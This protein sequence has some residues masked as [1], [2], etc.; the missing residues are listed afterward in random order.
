[1]LPY[2]I[3]PK[4]KTQLIPPPVTRT[5]VS[6]GSQEQL[7]G[8]VQGKKASDLEERAANSHYELGIP[9][10]FR[11]RISVFPV[12]KETL[13]PLRSD[14]KEIPYYYHLWQIEK[15]YTEVRPLIPYEM[16]MNLAGELE[17]DILADR[18]GILWPI[19]IDGEIGHHMTTAQRD[20]DTLKTD[21]INIALL[22]Y[23][24][25]GVV[26]VP[27]WLLKTQDQ[28]DEFFENLYQEI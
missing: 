6:L 11:T 22:P 3:A 9:F 7:T 14:G 8:I 20:L 19:L 27:F 18:H 28:S 16:G 21:A 5:P 24:A 17:I 10:T 12:P 4:Q 23:G 13:P 15:N 2:W 1:M 26:R 25:H